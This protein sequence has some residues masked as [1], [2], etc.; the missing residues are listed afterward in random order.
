MI[1]ALAY[2]FILGMFLV[3]GREITLIALWFYDNY[4]KYGRNY[5]QW[6]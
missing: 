1:E 5:Q 4:K 3:V 6:K 2:V